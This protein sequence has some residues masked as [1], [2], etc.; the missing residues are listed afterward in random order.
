VTR[1][2]AKE[3]SSFNIRVLTL[4]LGGFNTSM[5]SKI[6]FGRNSLPDD[7]KGTASEQMMHFLR[8]GKWIPKGDKDKAM[9]AVYEV[10]VGEGVG[11][12][13]EAEK[14]LLLG[15]DMTVRARVVQDYLSHSLEVF[16]QSV[17]NNVS[18]DD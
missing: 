18:V 8:S 15:S 2:L 1:V 13:H 4:V 11:A 17:T 14:L 9:K 6:T 3:V 16:G 7:Y 12:G 5:G 10:V